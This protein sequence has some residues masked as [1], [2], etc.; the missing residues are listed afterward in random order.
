MVATQLSDN[1]HLLARNRQC[2]F[3][4]KIH[5]HQ[6]CFSRTFCPLFLLA[7]S[8][9]SPA[10]GTQS[11]PIISFFHKLQLFQT[12]TPEFSRCT[13]QNIAEN[14][15]RDKFEQIGIGWQE[16]PEISNSWPFLFAYSGSGKAERIN[17]LRRQAYGTDQFI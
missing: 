1:Y 16:N 8:T 13:N 14:T 4:G 3:P 11:D 5:P 6:G 7:S 12:F 2:S 15:L 9:D 10:N 17:A